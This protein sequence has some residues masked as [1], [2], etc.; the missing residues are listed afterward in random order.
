MSKA[1][2]YVILG[3]MLEVIWAIS[4]KLSNGFTDTFYSVI[5]IVFVIISFYLFSKG[6]SLLPSGVAYTVF[7][8]IGAVG[9]IIVSILF[10]NES[11]T[12][13]KIFFS[14]VLIAAI[15]NLKMATGEES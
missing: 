8:G 3:G 5:T 9:T 2:I 15:I 7:T 6:M 14:I 12:F 4:L 10:L 13:S 11:V 1:W